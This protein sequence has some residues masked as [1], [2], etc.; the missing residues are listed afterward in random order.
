MVWSIDKFFLKAI[1]LLDVRIEQYEGNLKRL[2]QEV[3]VKGCGF[4]TGWAWPYN[5][6]MY[7]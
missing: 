3:V 6:T 1:Y 2:G 4:I 5:N 7:S